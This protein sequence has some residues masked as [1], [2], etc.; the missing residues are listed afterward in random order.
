M[1]NVINNETGKPLADGRGSLV[2]DWQG[3]RVG[4]V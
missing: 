3:I 2:I 4:L 1:S